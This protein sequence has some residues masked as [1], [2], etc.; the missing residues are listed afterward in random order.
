MCDRQPSLEIHDKK[1]YFAL[2]YLEFSGVFFSFRPQVS[3]IGPAA[4]WQQKGT[5]GLEDV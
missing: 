1:I 4:P 5:N 2:K 3:G